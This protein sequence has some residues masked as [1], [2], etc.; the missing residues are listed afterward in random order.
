MAHSVYSSAAS[1][2]FSCALVDA[3]SPSS[4]SSCFALACPLTFGSLGHQ[5][6]QTLSHPPRLSLR[7]VVIQRT[8]SASLA[9]S[10]A[11][12]PTHHAPQRGGDHGNMRSIPR[13]PSLETVTSEHCSFHATDPTEMTPSCQS[14]PPVRVE[15]LPLTTWRMD[16]IDTQ[17]G[18]VPAIPWPITK[19]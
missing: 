8:P 9:Q 4:T 11:M 1:P 3:S 7:N 10:L 5:T 13:C 19:N 6:D 17:N 12:P 2:L 16:G 18:I 14:I 15:D